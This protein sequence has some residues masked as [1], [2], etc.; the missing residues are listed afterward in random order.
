[1][2]IAF[3]TEGNHKQGMGDL[4]GSL[5]LAGECV[6][7]GDEV[8]FVISGGEEATTAI[9]DCGHRVRAVDSLACEQELYHSFRPDVILV[10]KLDNPPDYVRALKGTSP[11]VVTV[12]DA[13]EGAKWADLNINA[14]YPIPGAVTGPEYIMLRDEFRPMRSR[15]RTVGKTVTELL[16]TQGGSD[17]Y[18]FTPKIVQALDAMISRPHC[19]VVV[20]PAFRHD[21]ELR[22]ALDA[23]RL[24]VSVV[25]NARNMADLMWRADLAITAGGVTMFELA[26]V[27]TPSLVICGELFEIQTARRLEEAGAM[28]NLGFGGDLD[29]SG[30]AKA[31]DGLAEDLEW[32]RRL[33]LRGKS[34]LDGRGCERIVRLIRER[35]AALG[36]CRS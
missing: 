30:V 1:V 22:E 25:R 6:R 36:G 23:S 4:Y 10:N 14:L 7:G 18:G 16:I 24:N 15:D 5:A 29:Y 21:G 32:R 28:V 17:T 19:T 11:F 3:R 12:D 33:S 9:A 8:L 13:G 35:V 31:V 34:L 27:G 26:A 2:R 20:G